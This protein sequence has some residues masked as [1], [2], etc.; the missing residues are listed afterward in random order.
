MAVAWLHTLHMELGQVERRLTF[1]S[2]SPFGRPGIDYSSEY[3]VTA[4]PLFTKSD[5]QWDAAIVANRE[6]HEA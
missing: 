4:E 5:N 6:E 1:N 2:D 3:S